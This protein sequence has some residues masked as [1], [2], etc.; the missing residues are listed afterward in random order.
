MSSG[1]E[2]L[3]MGHTQDIHLMQATYTHAH[4]DNL[5]FVHRTCATHQVHL[6]LAV[7]QVEATWISIIRAMCK[8]TGNRLTSLLGKVCTAPS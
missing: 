7:L 3:S 4:K 6:A 1:V 8:Y 5:A 2:M